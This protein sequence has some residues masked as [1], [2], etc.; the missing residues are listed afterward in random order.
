VNLL[1][2]QGGGPTPV[3]NASLF[4]VVDEARRSKEF[5]RALGARVGFEGAIRGDVFDF[6]SVSDI[7]LQR[8]KLSPG[9]ALKSTRHKLSGPDIASIL[10]QLTRLDVGALLVIGGNGTLRG[11]D[12]ISHAAAAADGKLR[13]IGVPKTIDNDIPGTDRCPGFASAARHAAQAV[14]D[15]GMDV[16]TLPQPVSI[17]ETMGRTAGWI[18]GA[19][20]LGKLD[21]DHAPH[22]IYLPE[23]PFDTEKF[24]ADVDRVV[25]R[26]G[27]CVAVVNEGIRTV[28]GAPV[29]EVADA[30]QRDALGRAMPGGVAVHLADV[31]TRNLKI[32]CR[33]EKPGLTGR[34]SMLHVA[35][36]DLIDAETVGRAGVRAAIEGHRGVMVALTP[37]GSAQPTKLVRLAAHAGGERVVPRDWLDAQSDTA[38][39][40]PFVG[41]VKPLVGELTAYPPPLV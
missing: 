13:V 21:A 24:L 25:R 12:L 34:A 4:G 7:D 3:V 29:Y 18:A 8:L 39:A 40:Q 23:T 26:F 5:G 16:R 31:V 35:P 37:L 1:V 32:R 38:V 11:A 2:L 10:T 30:T 14:R 27:W 20:I 17:F 9:A 15:L 41:Y 19:T 36:Q 28:T 33:W 6:A 22:L